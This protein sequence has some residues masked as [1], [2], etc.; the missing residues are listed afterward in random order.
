MN[1]TIHIILPIYNGIKYL[2]QQIES[3]REQTYDN[4]V[5][6]LRDDGSTDGSI[7]LA[8][9][10]AQYDSRI[11]LLDDDKGNLGA[12]Q[13]FSLLAIEALARGATYVAFSD[14]DDVWLPR[15]LEKSL[16]RIKEIEKAKEAGHNVLVHSDLEVVGPNLQ[17]IARSFMKHERIR[18]RRDVPISTLLVQNHV[19]GCTMMTNRS[20]LSKAAPIPE[21][22]RMH[23][24]WIAA[25]ATVTGTVGYIA[26]P[27]VKYRQHGRNTLGSSG[28]QSA[29][30]PFSMDWIRRLKKR[31]KL[32]AATRRLASSLAKYVGYSTATEAGLLLQ[33]CND[34]MQRKHSL[35]RL[36]CAIHNRMHGQNWLSTAIF[37]VLLLGS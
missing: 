29:F 6:L 8:Q 17:P 32:Q 11:E 3:I 18:H 28:F 2:E 16:C 25:F 33:R 23:D 7:E 22:V 35:I 36:A 20:L 27:L 13:A 10:L 26:E 19:V 24:W 21:G 1:D 14:Q 15:K 9:R 37:Y 31:P 30:L 34:C 12:A 4:W 5:L